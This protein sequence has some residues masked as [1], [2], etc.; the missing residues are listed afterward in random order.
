[1]L[2][3]VINLCHYPLRKTA[4]FLYILIARDFVSVVHVSPWRNVQATKKS[5]MYK[6][7]KFATF[8]RC[9]RIASELAHAH[10]YLSICDG[11]R[12]AE[13]VVGLGTRLHVHAHVCTH[14]HT[15]KP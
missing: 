8:T 14:T 7:C 9:L 3:H 11:L 5:Y 2:S 1:M 6:K 10:N 4:A 13:K 15:H 12:V